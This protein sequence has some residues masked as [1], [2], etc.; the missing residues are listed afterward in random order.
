MF[1]INRNTLLNL[2]HAMHLYFAVHNQY[3]VISKKFKDHN[4]LIEVCID[5]KEYSH[6]TKFSEENIIAL[7]GD[8]N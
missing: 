6:T 4:N 7:S 8:F 3:R 1:G 5:H 2:L